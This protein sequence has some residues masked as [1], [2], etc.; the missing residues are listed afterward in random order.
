MEF[1]F[2]FDEDE[3][4]PDSVRDTGMYQQLVRI[5][6]GEK[7]W[8]ESTAYPHEVCFQ[9]ELCLDGK[10]LLARN[11]H[12]VLY[13]S[14]SDAAAGGNLC[15]PITPL[16]TGALVL[17]YEKLPFDPPPHLAVASKKN[18][19]PSQQI[20]F[21]TVVNTGGWDFDSEITYSKDV[22]KDFDRSLLK[23]AGRLADHRFWSTC[24][25]L[26]K[27]EPL[28]AQ[29]VITDWDPSIEC[30]EH[31][32]CWLEFQLASTNALSIWKI[33]TNTARSNYFKALERLWSQGVRYQEFQ[34]P[35]T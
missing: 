7:I 14:T 30:V 12:K 8:L 16:R 17:T 11:C 15:P 35:Q 28:D 32:R 18:L 3:L 33:A 5:A 19:I 6:P 24:L 22:L 13:A 27:T 25:V 34:S 26:S 20:N 23:E 1:S 2:S 10:I 4:F 9:F 21:Q 31:A 29:I